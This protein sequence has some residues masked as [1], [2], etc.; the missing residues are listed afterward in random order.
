MAT[1]EGG[2]NFSLSA[3]CHTLGMCLSLVVVAVVFHWIPVN[4]DLSF[5][6]PR[7][8]TWESIVLLVA[9]IVYTAFYSLGVAP[10]SWVGTEFLPLEVR[11]LG[12]MVNTVTC[13]GS[14]AFGF[15]AGFCSLGWLF[16][17]LCYA[18][19][20][21][22]PLE[23]VREIYTDGFG[24]KKAKEIQKQLKQMRQDEELNRQAK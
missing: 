3:P 1:S 24:V 20:H 12:T 15:Y 23:S 16:V 6:G 2:N 9:L 19:V 10:T 18:E 14:G 11:A 22:M 21:N 8:M 13:C 17:T 7:E 5:S 4:I